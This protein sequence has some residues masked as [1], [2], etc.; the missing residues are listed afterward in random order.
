M[1][2]QKV[3]AYKEYKKNKDKI[4]KREKL[5]KRVEA[6]IAAAVVVAFVA[7]FGWSVYNSA[8][9]TDE[10]APAVVTEIQ[11]E[12]YTDYISSLQS[13]FTS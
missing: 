4:L 2:Q 3:N 10:S 7:W 11:A 8:T 9:T 6:A 12:G 1:S 13:T 5:M